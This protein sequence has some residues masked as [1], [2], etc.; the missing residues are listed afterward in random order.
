MQCAPNINAYEKELPFFN[1]IV[2]FSVEHFSEISRRNWSVAVLHHFDSDSRQ[3]MGRSSADH[4]QIMGRS[5][6]DHG[7]SM[8]A[9]KSWKYQL[10]FFP[11]FYENLRFSLKKQAKCN[12]IFVDPVSTWKR[13]KSAK[14]KKSNRLCRA[15]EK[16]SSGWLLTTMDS[17][18][19]PNLCSSFSS[20]VLFQKS[21]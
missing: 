16:L 17:M 6:A 19:F 20:S 2:N 15:R 11:K 3:I 1:I 13:W 4:G 21:D 8:Y 5:W 10:P 7:R 14:S 18:V 9:E 12:I